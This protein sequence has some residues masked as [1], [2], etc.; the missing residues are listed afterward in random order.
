M[1]ISLASL[2]FLLLLASTA[3][4]AAPLPPAFLATLSGADAGP[5]LPA[6]TPAASN[7]D[8][9]GLPVYS[10]RPCPISSA[11]VKLCSETNCGTYVIV[12]CDACALECHLPPG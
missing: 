11:P 5:N 10:C 3:V 6:F 7:A 12:H 2:C 9:C 1:K 4:A 8:S